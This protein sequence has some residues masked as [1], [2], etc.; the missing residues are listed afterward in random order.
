M[1]RDVVHLPLR[2][3][4]ANSWITAKT[5]KLVDHHTLLHRKGMLS[6]ATLRSLGRKVK[7][8]LAADRLLRASNTA[9]EIEG[10]IAAGEFVEAWH[11]LKGWY[12]SVEDQAPKA[13]PEMLALQMAERVELYTAVPPLGWLLPINLTPISVPDEPPT[14]PE[15]LEVGEKLQNGRAAGTTGMKV[16]HLKELLCGI[17]HEEVEESP[18]GGRGS[19]EAVCITNTDN[20]GE[21]HHANSVE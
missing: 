11:H 8:C 6:Q 9:S 17:R 14:D 5:W 3:C 1:Q 13:C 21:R 4:P 15:I 16:K 7:A 19:L 18:G 12:Q 20:L 2:E 10:K